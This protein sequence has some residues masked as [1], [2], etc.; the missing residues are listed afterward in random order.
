MDRV[1][2]VD[3]KAYGEIQKFF[4][5]LEK[6][7]DLGTRMHAEWEGCSR[8]HVC[9]DLY[10]VIWQDL[11][12]VEDYAGAA[13]DTVVPVVILRV[14]PKMLPTGETIYHQPRPGAE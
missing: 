3:R 14:G 8:A 13:G 9:N 12:E 1:K 11:P 6:T 10:R 7:G 2:R 5:D 4:R